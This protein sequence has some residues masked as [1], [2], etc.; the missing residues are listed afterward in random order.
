MEMKGQAVWQAVSIEGGSENAAE[1]SEIVWNANGR[2]DA[3]QH[4]GRSLPVSGGT[5]GRE[6]ISGRTTV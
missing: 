6:T 3:V 2:S 5:D 4:E 1:R